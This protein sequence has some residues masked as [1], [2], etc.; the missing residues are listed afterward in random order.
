MMGKPNNILRWA[1][2][3]YAFSL[4]YEM[5]S[6]PGGMTLPK[7]AGLLYFLLVLPYAPIMFRT[8][9]IA[10][11]VFCVVAMPIVF[12]F[13]NIINGGEKLADTSFLLNIGMF[14]IIMNHYRNDHR[15]INDFIIWYTLGAI[16]LTVFFVLGIGVNISDLS[17]R[18]HMFGDDEN[19]DTNA[20]GT[21]TALAIIFVVY[22]IIRV[23]PLL[24]KGVLIAALAGMISL[25]ALLASRTGLLIWVIGVAGT[26]FLSAKKKVYKVAII[27]GV[28]L[29]GVVALHY[30]ESEELLIYNR[31]M[32]SYEDKDLSG[33]DDIWKM[34][35]P[36]I[37]QN[38]ILGVGMDGMYEWGKSHGYGDISPHNVFIEVTLYGGIFGLLL[39]SYFVWSIIVLRIKR[40]RKTKEFIYFSF[41]LPMLFQLLSGQVLY[42]KLFWVLAALSIAESL[43]LVPRKKV[44]H[45]DEES[46]VYS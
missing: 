4:H 17:G 45:Q 20:I 35:L 25:S 28:I 5:L 13:S 11:Y 9:R 27:G 46:I 19:T 30:A 8:D 7:I 24:V 6:L 21:R 10:Q 31:I 2:C 23:K 15:I 43:Q 18:M 22:L 41:L 29:L 14:W 42:M 3:L 37:E 16:V 39:L 33:R 44:L 32:N 12:M 40:Y 34:Y 38:P 36:A 1:F 26:L